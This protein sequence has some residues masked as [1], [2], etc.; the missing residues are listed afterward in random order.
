MEVMVSWVVLP[1]LG[2]ACHA[3]VVLPRLGGAATPGWCCHAWVRHANDRRL[4]RQDWPPQLL[5]QPCHCVGL[6]RQI[7]VLPCPALQVRGDFLAFL[8]TCLADCLWVDQYG[9]MSHLRPIRHR[10]VPQHRQAV[11]HL[12]S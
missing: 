10:Q 7:A 12:A 2:A 4:S 9:A 11:H 6:V 5:R 8:R 3:W 1:R